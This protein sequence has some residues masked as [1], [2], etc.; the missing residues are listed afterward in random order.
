M[1][2]PRRLADEGDGSPA[3]R[4]RAGVQAQDA[5]S[6]QCDDQAGTEE[7]L[8]EQGGGQPGVQRVTVH[9]GAVAGDRELAQVTQIQVLASHTGTNGYEARAATE[10]DLDLSRRTILR[11]R[12]HRARQ[13]G[14]D[15][16]IPAKASER[17][18]GGGG[19]DGATGD[20]MMKRRPGPTRRHEE[21]H[22]AWA[23]RNGVTPR[24]G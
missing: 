13:R 16:R 23:G 19:Q 9:P 1:L 15:H 14:V 4:H 21:A 2:L 18:Q 8:F 10:E 11:R 12:I 22:G 17:R 24:R 20:A 6:R 7:K 3:R 5:A